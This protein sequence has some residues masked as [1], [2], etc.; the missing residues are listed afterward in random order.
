MT[1]TP[2]SPYL[3]ISIEGDS[4]VNGSR[5]IF[6]ESVS[7]EEQLEKFFSENKQ[8]IHDAQRGVELLGEDDTPKA[9]VRTRKIVSAVAQGLEILAALHPA[10]KVVS[11]AFRIVVNIGITSSSQGSRIDAL[12][13]AMTQTVAALFRL[14]DVKSLPDVKYPNGVVLNDFLKPLMAKIASDIQRC[15]AFCEIYQKDKFIVRIL[16]FSDYEDRITQFSKQFADNR[17]ELYR[18]LAVNTATKID[19]VDSKLDD[20]KYQ[21]NTI[22]E[23]LDSPRMKDMLA[24]VKDNGGPQ[25][26]IKSNDL[27]ET[28]FKKSGESRAKFADK[29]ENERVDV[30][31][32]KSI[33][34]R[35]MKE[36]LEGKMKEHLKMLTLR[37]Q[38][39]TEQLVHSVRDIVTAGAHDKIIHEDIRRLWQLMGWPGSV[40]A[41]R[42]AHALRDYFTG[43]FI[44]RS[45]ELLSNT[46]SE[47]P[48]LPATPST[49]QEEF[50]SSSS[51]TTP[52]LENGRW[53]ITYLHVA[54]LQTILEAI[55]DDGTGFISIKEANTFVAERPEDWSLLQWI[56]FWAQGWE[57][58]LLRYKSFIIPMLKEL[59]WIRD[60][61]LEANVTA[62]DKYLYRCPIIDVERIM[63]SVKTAGAYGHVHPDLLNLTTS[64]VDREEEKL[65]SK[66]EKCGYYVDKAFIE[67][68]ITSQ[69]RIERFLFPLLYLVLRYHIRCLRRARKN[70]V[71]NEYFFEFLALSLKSILGAVDERLNSLRAIH[72]QMR[73]NFDAYLENAALGM[74]RIYKDMQGK[75]YDP[76]EDCLIMPWVEALEG[77]GVN[78][79]TQ[80]FYFNGEEPSGMRQG[81]E[82]TPLL[83][84]AEE[85][86]ENLPG[87]RLG[88]L[89]R[90]DQ[91]DALHDIIAGQ[92]TGYITSQDASLLN[93]LELIQLTLKFTDTDSGTIFGRA[94]VW[95]GEFKVR[96]EVHRLEDEISFHLIFDY[97][98]DELLLLRGTFNRGKGVLA[99][100]CAGKLAD[101]AE[102]IDDFKTPHVDKE[103]GPSSYL[104]EFRR[105]PAEVFH[106]RKIL[107][108]GANK[109][110]A[111]WTFL[112]NAIYTLVRQDLCSTKHLLGWVKNTMTF[113][114]LYQR[115]ALTEDETSFS[116]VKPLSAAER[117]EWAGLKES[118]PPLTI[119]PVV[120]LM[121]WYNNRLPS[122]S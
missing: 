41:I 116:D 61:V 97:D 77:V 112:R 74:F 45:S 83:H 99:G 13:L 59:F 7:Y 25:S 117:Q 87:W 81:F 56:A 71:E 17:D 63:R 95:L 40:E 32:I 4:V 70:L 48:N 92:W 66:L 107:R 51:I 96:G 78:K 114:K 94:E 102:Q 98:D 53:E 50:P 89:E 105:C 82:E 19:Q 29:G 37:L 62:V 55:D 49:L 79:S 9:L 111:R 6:D 118:M 90:N 60:T 121:S 27:I 104:F 11:V 23:K 16:K 100:V 12:R 80:D 58:S 84:E 88:L 120:R 65:R 18:A 26:V 1:S 15:L 69:G 47:G 2:A 14:R 39:H 52:H 33:L 86:D 54:S 20:L 67:K 42:F 3:R 119:G 21:L 35:E 113:V 103:Y 122:H 24:W 28:L 93:D 34:Q 109:A 101:S 8:L 57:I 36:T 108:T 31:M 64:Y 110:Q 76:A 73:S 30:E 46:E 10:V 22:L 72:I 85:G 43:Q 68:E 44:V 38:V 106:L 5:E 115:H 75:R 91:Y